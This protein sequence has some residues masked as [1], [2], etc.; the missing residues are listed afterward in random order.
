MSAPEGNQF[1]KARAASG[2]EKIFSSPEELWRA[3]CEYFQWCDDNPWHKN[4][5]V[6]GG[7]LAGKIIKVPT[8]RPY[9]ITGL[10]VFLDI[11]Q[12]T[13]N[14]Y[15]TKEGYEDFFGIC[16]RIREVIYTQ[17]FEGAAVGAFNAN[18]IA[19]DLG[20]KEKQDVAVSTP[21]G[22]SVTYQLQ[23][24]NEPLADG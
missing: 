24:G 21:Q 2:R 6:K 11:D 1:W 20:L 10:S 13:F 15:S 14:N 9:T 8:E 18:I 17:K 4:E 23:Q 5:A 12:E 7:D 22:I 19:R 3:A 16:T